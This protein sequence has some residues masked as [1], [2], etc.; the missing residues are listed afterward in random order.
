MRNNHECFTIHLAGLSKLGIISLCIV[1]SSALSNV[2]ISEG[3]IVTHPITPNITP[4]AI[5]IPRS[6]P[7]VKLIK[8]SAIN[9]A[10][11]VIDEPTTEVS[12]F[13]IA[14]A[15]A[16]LWSPEFFSFSSL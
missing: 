14:T 13:P 12:V 4:F 10:T 9:P 7:R 5:T 16:S 1:F 6:S 15:I 11:V 3:R 2:S 8:Q